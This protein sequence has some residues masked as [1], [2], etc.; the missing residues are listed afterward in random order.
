[1]KNKITLFLS[2]VILASCSAPKYSYY[3]SHQ[4]KAVASS[5]ATGT[6]TSEVIS[7]DPQLLEASRAESPVVFS[8]EVSTTVPVS[9]TY[10]QMNKG[11]RKAL[12]H[13]LKKEIK[14]YLSAKKNVDSANSAQASGMDHDLKLAII[15]GAVGIVGLLIGTQVFNIIGGIALLIGVIFFVKWIIRQ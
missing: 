14:T 4:K 8:E 11:E 7:M 2:I 6:K 1:M 15:F 5:T 12:R 13:Q 3:F 9:K 10:L